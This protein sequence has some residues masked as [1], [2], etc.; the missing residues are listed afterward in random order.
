MSYVYNDTIELPKSLDHHTIHIGDKVYYND[1]A[2][3]ITV[4][5][6]NVFIKK[7]EHGYNEC[8]YEM[9][10][11]NDDRTVYDAFPEELMFDRDDSISKIADEMDKYNYADCVS[12]EN[13]AKRLHK[14]ADSLGDCE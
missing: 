1:E 13:W 7:D 2:E 9:M 5:S 10:G 3:P 14:I 12:V 8:H 4:D 6:I 11:H